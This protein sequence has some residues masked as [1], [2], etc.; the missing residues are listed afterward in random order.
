[1]GGG[2]LSR[3]AARSCWAA[4]H[5]RA[6]FSRVVFVAEHR[7][8]F[9]GKNNASHTKEWAPAYVIPILWIHYKLMILQGFLLTSRVA[10]LMFRANGFN[11]R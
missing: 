8:V 2:E 9:A 6:I 10:G 3:C 5:S 11:S 4:R 1:L 7:V